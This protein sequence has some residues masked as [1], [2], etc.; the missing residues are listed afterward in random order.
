MTLTM[1]LVDPCHDVVAA[2]LS[3]RRGVLL[4]SIGQLIMMT[5]MMLTMMMVLI[6]RGRGSG[7]FVG[8]VS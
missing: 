5:V 6:R 2:D 7:G 4:G 8:L 3:T 1:L